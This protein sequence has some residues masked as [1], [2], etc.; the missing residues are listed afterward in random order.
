MESDLDNLQGT[1]LIVSLEVEGQKYPPAGSSI[2]VTGSDFVSLNMGA[3]YEGHVAVNERVSPNTIDLSFTQ[4]P[5]SG[6]VALGIYELDGDSWKLCLGFAGKKRPERFA[7]LPGSG[8]ALETL[9]RQRRGSAAGASASIDDEAWPVEALEGEWL[10]TTCVQDGHPIDARMV[11][12]MRRVFQGGTTTLFMGVKP[13]TTTRF[14]L[15]MS[16]EPCQI[17]YLDLHQHGIFKL[18]DG[19]LTTAMVATT[20]D[21]ATGFDA[22]VDGGGHTVSSWRR[23]S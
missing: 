1:W 17:S 18:S 8:H 9:K 10:M 12:S 23:P 16:R 6:N 3:T 22:I 13:Y 7:A 2:V 21:R 19:V 15:D 20:E 5:E 11:K 14:T 4:G